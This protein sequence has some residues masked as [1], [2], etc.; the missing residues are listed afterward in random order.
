MSDDLTGL[1]LLYTT[2]AMRRLGTDPVDDDTV[3]KILDGAI[4]GP[5][6]ANRMRVRFGVV[7]DSD[8]KVRIQALYEQGLKELYS[9]TPPPPDP[10]D[11]AGPPNFAAIKT[12]DHLMEHLHEAPVLLFVLGLP[13]FMSTSF[14][15][16]WQAC[17]TAR[18]YGIG[19]TFT[20]AL[21]FRQE[22]IDSI[23]G[24]PEDN[25]WEFHAMLPLGVPLGNWGLAKRP[26][27]NRFTYDETFGNLVDWE[28]DEP[29][30]NPAS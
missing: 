1:E 6:G 3:A 4:R 9:M 10:N 11:P 19:T 27:V 24:I 5:S 7:R 8:R 26:P 14:P 28:I 21:R 12:G 29:Y 23:L 18:S 16:A 17:L 30:W 15:I 25:P 22:E 20:T 13:G 2:R